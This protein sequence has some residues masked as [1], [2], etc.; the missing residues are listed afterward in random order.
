M[1]ALRTILADFSRTCFADIYKKKKKKKM[2]IG[3]PEKSLTPSV[4]VICNFLTVNH[5]T[6]CTPG[7]SFS[8]PRRLKT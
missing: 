3:N 1:D 6:S 5:V 7:R 8:S 2:E 4:V